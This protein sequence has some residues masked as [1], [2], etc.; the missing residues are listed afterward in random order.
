MKWWCGLVIVASIGCGSSPNPESCLD[1]SCTDPRF[2]YCDVEG[3][4]EQPGTC[5]EVVCAAGEFKECREDRAI[6]CN[7]T[8]NNYDLVDCPYG[9]DENGCLP[10]PDEVAC[11]TNAQCSNPAPVCGGDMTCRGCNDNNECPSTVC[12]LDTGAC[13]AAAAI[14]YASPTG[15]GTADCSLSTPCTLARAT[16]QASLNLGKT[17]RLL[18]GNYNDNFDISGNVILKVVATGA[19]LGTTAQMSVTG[20]ATVDLRDL[21]IS[22]PGITTLTCGDMSAPIAKST[23]RLTRVEAGLRINRCVLTMVGG[24]LLGLSTTDDASLDADGVRVK[25]G[26]ASTSGSRLSLRFLNSIFDNTVISLGNNDPMGSSPG[27]T[28][29]VAFSTFLFSTDGN[30]FSCNTNTSNY[31]RVEKFENNIL[32]ATPNTNR[33]YVVFM[34]RTCLFSN[35]IMFPQSSPIAGNPVVDPQ[36]VDVAGQDYHL[37]VGSPAANAG[38]P[39]TGLTT[40]H[41]FDGV[42]RPQ[43]VAHDIGAFELH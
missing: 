31:V 40:T 41:D 8:G 36:L 13:T 4:F 43:G 35:N 3:F 23:V 24:Q 5:I 15:S 38:L 7:A 20:G 16:M 33:T 27:S 6:T 26:F 34:P 25:F 22:T 21:R 37:K 19:T 12:E 30:F 9:C 11:T 18:P 2:P 28:L 29:S 39:S 42:A 1:G 10:P 17:L 32:L 14:V